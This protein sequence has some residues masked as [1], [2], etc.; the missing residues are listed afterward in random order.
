LPAGHSATDPDVALEEKP[1][2]LTLTTDALVLDQV[3]VGAPAWLML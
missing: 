2:P 1:G 3:K